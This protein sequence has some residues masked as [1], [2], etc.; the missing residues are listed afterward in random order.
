MSMSNRLQNAKP[1]KL[2]ASIFLVVVGHLSHA[3]IKKQIVEVLVHPTSENWEYKVGEQADFQ[4]SVLQYGRPINEVEIAYEIGPEKMPVE[5]QGTLTLK[6]GTTVL[7][8]MA[9]KE[10]GFV[11]CNVTATFGGKTY[12]GKGTAGI[13]PEKIEA[14]TK[15][16]S[17]F[18]TFWDTAKEALAKIP[19]DP[20]LTLVP[21]QCTPAV[22][23]YH[24]ELANIPN[25]WMGTSK[26][27]GMLS[28]PKKPGKYPAILNVPGAGAR[29][30]F[31]DYRAEQGVICFNVGIHGVPVNMEQKV[32][33]NLMTGALNGY[34]F[35]QLNNKDA[36]FYKRVYLGCVRAVDFIYSMPEFDGENLAV[37]GGSQGGALSII[38][39]ALDGRVKYLAAFYPALSDMA[40]Y[41]E[42]RAG[43]WPHM[44]K[45]ADMEENPTWLQNTAYYDVVNFA[46]KLEIPGW[47]SWGFNDNICPPT[48]MHAA[49]NSI[50]APKELHIY[51]DSGHWTYPEQREQADAW[52]YDKLGVAKE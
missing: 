48:S 24:V 4:V 44:F 7:K 8:G 29:P 15:L 27:Y 39:A 11:R 38:T 50:E 13:A 3:Q 9:L 10:P 36:Y 23:V 32:Y 40:A 35:S 26:F 33:D 14:V 22:N 18:D 37:H 12:E 34:M 52:L 21:E 41:T 47:Y 25:T 1:L 30:Y 28:V 46:R 19:M 16:P 42:G 6:K 43:G 2:W 5:K 51:Q 49:Y 20:K 17:D 31:Y 45:Y